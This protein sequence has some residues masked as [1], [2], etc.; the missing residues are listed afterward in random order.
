MA[1]L[2]IPPIR[3]RKL[4]ALDFY[5]NWVQTTLF[6]SGIS[7]SD[8]TSVIRNFANIGGQIDMRL[9]LFS[10]LSSTF[11]VGYARAFDL[12]NDNFAY[13]EWM[14]SLKLL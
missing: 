5:S 1:E 2:V 13:D 6:V 8:E 14:I 12:D 10:V 7:Y 3:F 9:V 11:S 4:G